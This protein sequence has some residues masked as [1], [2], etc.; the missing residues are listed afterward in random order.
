MTT[1]TPKN[2]SQNK[3]S[4]LGKCGVCSG[5]GKKKGPKGE[6]TTEECPACDGTGTTTG[7]L[8]LTCACLCHFQ[9]FRPQYHADTFKCTCH[10]RDPLATPTPNTCP[11]CGGDGYLPEDYKRAHPCKT[12]GGTGTIPTETTSFKLTK[13]A[14]LSG[15]AI[16][17]MTS[18]LDAT[19]DIY[20]EGT[21]PR[22]P[23]NCTCTP[24]SLNAACPVHGPNIGWR[25][26]RNPEP[27][28]I[29][30]NTDELLE[31][32]GKAKENGGG[33]IHLKP[34]SYELPTIEDVEL[35]GAAPQTEQSLDE[36]LGE[37]I[38]PV[39]RILEPVIRNTGDVGYEVLRQMRAHITKAQ[40][41]AYKR[42]Y[43][44]GQLNKDAS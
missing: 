40:S 37:I 9:A 14:S 39:T 20:Y 23:E 5:T 36:A 33:V 12:C 8:E 3:R 11:T 32:I 31:A 27:R 2:D 7:I 24:S 41:E 38:N 13:D 35:V 1:P 26:E 17:E 6:P 16:P 43:I 29:V 4:E 28:T 30:S 25:T 22:N 18:A 19:D 10:C 42:G 44:D 21:I 15:M 34:G